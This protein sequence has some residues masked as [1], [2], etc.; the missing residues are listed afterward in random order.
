MVYLISCIYDMTPLR[1][2]VGAQGRVVFV[3]VERATNLFPRH[4]CPDPFVLVTA[5]QQHKSQ[6]AE[7]P[8]SGKSNSSTKSS[9]RSK[10]WTR[11]D[12][13]HST[14]LSL[15]QTDAAP[16]TLN[17]EWQQRC[18]LTMGPDCALGFTVQYTHI[19]ILIHTHTHTYTYSYIHIHILIHTPPTGSHT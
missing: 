3:S 15:F 14:A 19:H 7:S 16:F 11:S 6:K 1:R 12:M 4:L 8:E 13:A 2:R 5:Q 18:L 17:P 9:M 10:V